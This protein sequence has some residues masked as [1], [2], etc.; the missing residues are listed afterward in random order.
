MTVIKRWQKSNTSTRL[1][2]RKGA[3]VVLRARNPEIEDIV[4]ENDA[5]N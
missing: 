4:L 5:E 2:T 1:H 3:Q